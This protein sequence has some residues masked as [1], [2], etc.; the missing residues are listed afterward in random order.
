MSGKNNLP[1]PLSGLKEKVLKSS[2]LKGE[3]D[4]FIKEYSQPFIDNQKSEKQSREKIRMAIDHII[5]SKTSDSELR[6]TLEKLSE[7]LENELPVD[8][9]DLL[10]K[11]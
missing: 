6:S 7:E 1:D 9:I 11:I 5:S 10:K 3:I 4:S 2:N 8:L